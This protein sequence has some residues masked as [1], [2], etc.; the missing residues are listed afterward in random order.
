MDGQTVR[1]LYAS[2][3]IFG[4][5]GHKKNALKLLKAF[6]YILK[7][8]MTICTKDLEQSPIQSAQISRIHVN[9]KC[10]FIL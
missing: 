6:I 2:Q 5:G 10:P 1:F 8:E 7:A 3:K 4:G 9:D